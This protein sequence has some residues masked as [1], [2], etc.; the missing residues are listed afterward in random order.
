VLT[1]LLCLSKLALA[2]TLT[3]YADVDADGYGDQDAEP[4]TASGPVAGYTD[5]NLDCDDSDSSVHPDQQEVCEEAGAQVDTD[6][7][8]DTNSADGFS[9][10]GNPLVSL[11]V[12]EDL[13]SYGE[14]DIA[15]VAACENAAGYAANNQDCD[16]TDAEIHPGA[17][18]VCDLTDNDC[19][20]QIDEPELD[21]STSGCQVV[22]RDRDGDGYG[23]ADSGA[24]LCVYDGES[25]TALDGESYTIASGDCYDLDDTIK[26]RTC[27]DGIDNDGDGLSDERD[28]DCAAGLD[29]AGTATE[30]PEELLDGHDNDC[31]GHIPLIELDCDDDGA[32]AIGA[33]SAGDA[34]QTHADLGLSPCTGESTT[35]TCWGETLSLT[36]GAIDGSGLWSLAYAASPDA[37]GDRF[38]GGHREHASGAALAAGD[39]DDRCDAR[40]PLLTEACDGVDNDCTTSEDPTDDDGIPAALRD[41]RSVSGTVSDAEADLDGDGAL[42]CDSFDAAA[43]QEADAPAE[44]ASSLA[45]SDCDDTDADI[46]RDCAADTGDESDGSDKEEASGCGSTEGGAALLLFAGLAGLAGRRRRG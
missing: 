22:F 5:N 29:E 30:Q 3:L 18:E 26:P 24:C 1:T 15:A 9:T 40:S 2:G 20:S 44:C 31:D 36:C 38:D 16:D 7:N 34:Y 35:I 32:A 39:C 11:Y 13:D 25:A 21:P 28:P 45:S 19:D 6:C 4:I 10:V 46:Q 37:H 17:D 12:D 43:A 8:G 23:D 33:I 41:D 14:P 42:D 27:R